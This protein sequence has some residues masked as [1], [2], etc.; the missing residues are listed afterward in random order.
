MP[1]ARLWLFDLDNTLHDAGAWVFAQMN[2]TMQPTSSTRWASRRPRPTRCASGTGAA[3]ARRMLG[4]VRHHDVSPAHFLHETHRFPGLEQRVTG[5]RHD[6]AA[7]RAPARPPHRAH[8]RAA[9]LRDARAGRA[10][11]RAAVRRGAVHRG[12]AHVRPLAPQARRA[13]AAP[14]GRA[15]GRA[16]VALRAGGG[17]AGQRAG[18]APRRHAAG[19]DAALR[20]PRR[21]RGPRVRRWTSS[22]RR[23]HRQVLRRLRRAA[24]RAHA[25]GPVRARFHGNFAWCLPARSSAAVVC[26]N[27]FRPA[28]FGS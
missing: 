13:H 10:G 16:S 19:L 15:A 20:A 8:Q 22:E 24:V 7:H 27:G 4:L 26:K 28:H 9:R 17:L 12:H 25:D 5:H 2:D 14:G 18:R 6:L 11:H 23:A 1:R 21:A 3:T